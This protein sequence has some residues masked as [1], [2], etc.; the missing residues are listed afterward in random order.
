[1]N[2]KKIQINLSPLAC[3]LLG[4]ITLL[5]QGH[6]TLIEFPVP[7]EEDVDDETPTVA[8]LM[9]EIFEAV[10]AYNDG[11]SERRFRIFETWEL[12]EEKEVALI[13]LSRDYLVWP[14]REEITKIPQ[15]MRQTH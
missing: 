13:R 4:E 6:G 11:R 15:M 14:G 5:S 10:I 8:E 7:K 1:M 2:D 9:L 12:D 3:E